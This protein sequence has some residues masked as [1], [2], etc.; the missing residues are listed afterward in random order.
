MPDFALPPAAAGCG[1]EIGL[2]DGATQIPVTVSTVGTQVAVS[3][4][5][6]LD[7]RGPFPFV[8]DTGASE[9]TISAQLAD[10]LRLPAAGPLEEYEGVGCTGSEQPRRVSA[11]SAAGLPLDGQ[12]LSSAT[13]P[14]MGGPGQPDGLL[15]SDVLSRF[16]AVRLNFAQSSMVF[17][18]PEGPP[19][20]QPS[21]VQGPTSVP[22][23]ASLLGGLSTTAGSVVPLRVEIGPGITEILAFVRFGG[24]PRNLFGIDTGSSQ[25][26][27]SPSVAD[28]YQ[29]AAT[30]LAERQTTV[31][32]TITVPVRRSGPWSVGAAAL[33]PGPVVSVD[34]GP[35]LEAGFVGLVGADQLAHFGAVVFDYAGGRMI[36]GGQ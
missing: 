27:V 7:G 1:G 11:W 22:T 25:S 6:C 4:N 26:V 14:G 34:L 21:V 33:T 18:G 17:P 32:S 5:V 15:G 16:G 29:L 19:A 8:L 9:S 35:V 12:V 28:R 36:L 13:L 2:P 24:H 20:S 3:L 23:P 30:N 31:C 10:S